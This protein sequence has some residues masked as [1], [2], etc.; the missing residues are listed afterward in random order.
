[1]DR[2]RDLQMVWVRD[3][4][5]SFNPQANGTKRRSGPRRGL[6]IPHGYLHPGKSEHG[7]VYRSYQLYHSRDDIIIVP[8]SLRSLVT[9]IISSL[10]W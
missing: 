5:T 9:I 3:L 8:R 6:L 4:Y 2:V 1:M 10:E 7:E